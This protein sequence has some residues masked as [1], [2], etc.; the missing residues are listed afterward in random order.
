MSIGAASA[1]MGRRDDSRCAG[2]FTISACSGHSGW[3]STVAR[4]LSVAT[5]RLAKLLKDAKGFYLNT[6]TVSPGVSIIIRNSKV[7]EP[8]NGQVGI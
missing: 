5:K 2:W 1:Q 3:F 6:G 4:R 7:S 8:C